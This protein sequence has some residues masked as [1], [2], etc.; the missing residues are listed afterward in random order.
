M[1]F[2]KCE[3]CGGKLL[4]DVLH[5]EYYCKDCGLVVD[6]PYYLVDEHD[7]NPIRTRHDYWNWNDTPFLHKIGC[8]SWN[9]SSVYRQQRKNLCLRYIMSYLELNSDEKK[10]VYYILDHLTLKEL[11]GNAS[12]NTIYAGVCRYV[13]KC[14]RPLILRQFWYST[15]IF[16]DVGLTARVFHVIENNI[17]S[18]ISG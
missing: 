11:H 15:G 2:I 8:K 14:S 17:M 9:N 18:K 7:F 16:R 6:E 10:F 3:E 13:L 4:F 1:E 12:C 5:H